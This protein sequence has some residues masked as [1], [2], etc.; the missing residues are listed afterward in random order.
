VA[1]G[2]SATPTPTPDI[3]KIDLELAIAIPGVVSLDV[4]MQ[5]RQIV[6]VDGDQAASRT[7]LAICHRQSAGGGGRAQVPL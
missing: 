2:R 5:A 3:A 4:F 7:V 6:G 1:T